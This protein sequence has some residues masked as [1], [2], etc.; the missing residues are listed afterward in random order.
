MKRLSPQDCSNMEDIRAEIDIMDQQ[1]I[2]LFAQRFEYVKA[3]AKFKTSPD[4]VRAKARFEAMIQTRRQWA[5]ENGLSP[6]VIESLYT[7][8][9]NY[10]IS[11]ELKHWSKQQAHH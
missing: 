7:E 4:A 3:A 9:V 1:I 5:S 6:D 10:F 8:L 11:E 2:K